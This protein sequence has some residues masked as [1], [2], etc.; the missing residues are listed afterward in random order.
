M[1]YFINTSHIKKGQSMDRLKKLLSL[2]LSIMMLVPTLGQLSVAAEEVPQNIPEVAV[3]EKS[4]ASEAYT[5]DDF[6]VS[7]ISYTGLTESGKAKLAAKGGILEFPEIKSQHGNPVSIIRSSSFKKLGITKV[8]LNGNITEIN[9]SAFWDNQISEL[10]IPDSVKKIEYNA[11]GKNKISKLKLSENCDTIYPDTFAYNQLKEVVIPDCVKEIR[12]NAFEKNPG[13][14]AHGNKVVLHVA[15]VSKIN[16]YN[17]KPDTYHIVSKVSSGYQAEDFTYNTRYDHGKEYFEITG[18]SESGKEKRKSNH[19]LVIPSIID[20]KEVTSI[21][22]KAFYNMEIEN[23]NVKFTSVT[24]PNKLKII[25]DSAFAGNAISKIDFPNTL[26]T[27]EMN[28]FCFNKLEEVIIPESVKEIGMAA[29][30]YNNIKQGLAKIDNY[31]GKVKVDHQ[32]FSQQG[33]KEEYVKPTYLKAIQK[34]NIKIKETNGIVITTNPA[35]TAE[36]GKKVKIKYEIK[37]SS[38]EIAS[39]KVKKKYGEVKLVK[40][41]FVMPKEDVTIEA[42]LKDKYSTEKWCAEDFEF[43]TYEL[44]EIDDDWYINEYTVSGFSK[45]GI[46]KLKKNKNVVIPS[47]DARGV[48]PT[49]IHEDAF[50]GIGMDSVEIPGNY[51]H[52]QDRAFQNCGLKKVVL[53]EGLIYA[54]EK[55]FENNEIKEIKLPKTFKYAAN[56]A[57]KGNNLKTLKLPEACESI[58]EESFMNNKLEKVEMGSNVKIIYA[59]AFAGN[60]LKEVNIPNSIKN[61]KGNLDGIHATAFDNNP[62]TKNPTKPNEKKVIL[63]TPNKNNPNK[64]SNK[65]NYVVDPVAESKWEADDFTYGPTNVTI[66]ENNVKKDVSL[67]S[68]TGFTDKGAE[69]LKT[70]RELE[71]P[72]VDTKGAKVEAVGIKAFQCKPF[73]P[74][75]FDKL[76]IPEGYLV[77]GNYAFMFS[78]C[79]GDLVLPDSM[80]YVGDAAFFANNFTSLTVPAEMTEITASMVKRNKISKVIFKGDIES[81]GRLAFS[82]NEIEEITIP[83]SVK[84]IGDQAFMSNKGSDKYDGKVVIR[85]A[86]GKNPNKLKDKENYVVDPKSPGTNPSIDYEKWDTGD[87]DY[88]GDKVRGFSEQGLKKIKRNKNL[89]IP[90]L[91]PEGKPVKYI[92]IDAFRN[93]M[94]GFN[95]ESVVIPDT[96]VEI[97][98]YAFQFNKIKSV[99]MPRDL[100]KLGMGV[101]ML[102]G[103]EKIEWNDNIEYIDQACFYMCDLGTLKLPASVETIMDA[104][105]RKCSLKKVEFEKGSKLK[106]ISNYAFG[107]NKLNNINLPD[108]IEEI[109]NMSFFNDFS[110][111]GDNRFTELN[112]PA[113]LKKIGFQAFLNN[114][115]KNEYNAVI[116]HTPEGKNPGGL[117][118]D[119]GKTFVV[120]PKIKAN[121]EDKAALKKAIDEAKKID[122]NKMTKKF[123]GF[124]KKTLD[125]AEAAYEDD[126]ASKSNV[127][128]L[129]AEVHWA[130]KRSILNKLMHEKESLEP[131]KDKFD[132]AKWAAVE[133]AYGEAEK[134]LMVIN[135]SEDKFDY[136]VNGLTIALK[137]LDPSTDPLAGAKIYEGKYDVP[138][139]HYIAPYTIKV[140]VWIKEG[141]ILHVIDDGTVCDD[142]NDDEEHNGGY[143]RKA[144]AILFKY[145]DK[146]VQEVKKNPLGK[147]LGID[148]VSGATV[149]SHGFHMAI[150]DAIKDIETETPTPPVNP[151]TKIKIEKDEVEFIKGKT[152]KVEFRIIGLDFDRDKENVRVKVDGK[153]LKENVDYRLIKGSIIV[154]FEKNFLNGLSN[155][156]HKVRISTG[157]GD[158][159]ATIVATTNNKTNS[160]SNIGKIGNKNT[161]ITVKTSRIPTGDS[162]NFAIALAVMLLAGIGVHYT[163]RKIR[164]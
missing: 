86:S 66:T 14:P 122:Q 67:N 87:F 145:K 153:L 138:K 81:I 96:V 114:H 94:Q 104:A 164:K 149:T 51:T 147:K 72:K 34:F 36:A 37:D 162:T 7:G 98:D 80:A 73:S 56:K 157:K 124:F 21:G 120:D 156:R 4:L 41:E 59:R 32:A 111:G 141:K 78:G 55:A 35:G 101:F 130:N 119:P 8:K 155:G 135:L 82:E 57:F 10:V 76:K 62:G 31:A 163:R 92:G 125:S 88:S 85:T 134:N 71:L 5:S 63:W 1:K 9:N 116:I 106:L 46:E 25:C 83:D 131:D 146:T 79:G 91:T 107:D 161:K 60:N 144:L 148:S 42:V 69:K 43:K 38:K 49:W 27:I 12:V 84:N 39:L 26:E 65:G 151:D 152:E 109:G 100:K 158:V 117:I 112:V 24:L 89:V 113:S 150:Q 99:K 23:E 123:K 58:A 137:S 143:F 159:E 48:T 17:D 28:A 70:I 103:V 3:Q 105:F 90:D 52:I 30:A 142:P 129:T 45:K 74:A 127:N 22:K 75:K 160:S 20:G 115:A 64:L 139:S 53:N 136:L 102:A 2:I 95:I 29:F 140:K 33:K 47:T 18:L 11:F 126:K 110:A 77:I 133:T 118:D 61:K 40:D 54:N 108:G 154:S 50:K 121:A 6:F 44:G 13:D 97:E 132:P 19:A 68:V 15:D 16:F 128:A 93:L